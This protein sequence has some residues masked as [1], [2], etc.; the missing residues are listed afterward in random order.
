VRFGLIRVRRR[1]RERSARHRL[2]GRQAQIKLDERTSERRRV[3]EPREGNRKV[4]L[5][6]RGRKRGD[7][8]PIEQSVE[9]YERRHTSVAYALRQIGDRV[10]RAIRIDSDPVELDAPR[11]AESIQRLREQ[12]RNSIAMRELAWWNP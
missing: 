7:I 2:F 10:D 4:N 12:H 6:R 8:D 11:C 9:E 5:V 1:L 3:P